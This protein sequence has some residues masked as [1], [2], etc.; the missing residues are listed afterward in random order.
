MR[1][2]RAGGMLP[3]RSPL[4]PAS[5]GESKKPTPF[6]P[7]PTD[8]RELP[9]SPPFL[10]GLKDALRKLP[11]LVR[12]AKAASEARRRRRVTKGGARVGGA[13]RASASLSTIG[14]RGGSGDRKE[15]ETIVDSDLALA[16][17]LQ[18]E[19]EEA[20]GCEAPQLARSEVGGAAA[21]AASATSADDIEMGER[22]VGAAPGVSGVTPEVCAMAWHGGGV[23][24]GER[25]VVFYAAAAAAAA[26]ASPH[27]HDASIGGDRAP[28]VP[29]CCRGQDN[30]GGGDQY[31]RVAVPPQTS[32]LALSL[33]ASA[34]GSNSKGGNSSDNPSSDSLLGIYLTS[35]PDRHVHRSSSGGGG[36]GGGSGDGDRSN[37]A[38]FADALGVE[39]LLAGGEGRRDATRDGG[40]QE[41]E[42]SRT[43]AA[44]RAASPAGAAHARP[45]RMYQGVLRVGRR[46][47]R[48]F[49]YLGDTEEGISSSGGGGSSSS[50]PA[51]LARLGRAELTIPELKHLMVPP[52]HGDSDRSPREDGVEGLEG[53]S[54]VLTEDSPDWVRFSE[55]IE[56]EKGVV[57]SESDETLTRGSTGGGGVG[58]RRIMAS[59]SPDVS[60]GGGGGGGGGSC[61][62]VGEQTGESWCSGSS[63]WSN[64]KNTTSGSETSS[65][66]RTPPCPHADGVE[67]E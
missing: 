58:A 19:E 60:G 28:H 29:D 55:W 7:L 11:H 37:R 39:A 65:A 47:G 62:S 42:P 61:G 54:P 44:G 12:N 6:S 10:E 46:G 24:A 21:A 25:S 34:S 38:P 32:S 3:V 40:G 33:S 49:A 48:G 57:A 50:S 51:G 63:S 18:R 23:A 30:S 45:D 5:G 64:I 27:P 2:L 52:A 59:L 14:A 43:S 9:V 35:W 20:I 67:A 26:A 1:F 41:K 53:L 4:T 56:R 13:V 31:A 15:G 66:P 8:R 22:G 16:R 17:T 36:G